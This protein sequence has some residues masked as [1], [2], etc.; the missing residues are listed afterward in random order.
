MMKMDANESYHLG[1]HSF[2]S[3]QYFWVDNLG[4]TQ[5]GKFVVRMILLCES[6]GSHNRD[7]GPLE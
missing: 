1:G 6:Q 2:S 7:S 3:Y 4:K 5:E